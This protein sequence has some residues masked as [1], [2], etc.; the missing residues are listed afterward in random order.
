MAC[1]EVAAFLQTAGAQ[2][3]AQR[4]KRGPGASSSMT[5]FRFCEVQNRWR[6]CYS[7]VRK[8]M[9]SPKKKV[10][11]ASH[12]N[13][14]VSFRWALS[15]AHRPCAGPTEAN[16]FPET[17]GPPKVHGPRGHCPPA[18]LLGGPGHIIF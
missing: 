18:L 16:G 9:R 14:S 4:T 6:K 2:S 10:F 3:G 11:R 12:A 7:L 5:D 13:F 1:S 8:M 15:R 17:H